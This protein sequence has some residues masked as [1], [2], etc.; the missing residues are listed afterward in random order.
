MGIA[1]ESRSGGSDSLFLSLW[2]LQAHGADTHTQANTHS[3]VLPSC[4][5]GHFQVTQDG[6]EIWTSENIY[7]VWVPTLQDIPLSVSP[8]AL[9]FTVP[10]FCS[11]NVLSPPAKDADFLSTTACIHRALLAFTVSSGLLLDDTAWIQPQRPCSL[12]QEPQS[13]S[14]PGTCD[15][16]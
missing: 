5:R 11:V 6:L 4:P 12:T 8:Y 3:D 16:L 10:L 13:L 2:V 14:Q 7:S 9:S 1:G 15:N